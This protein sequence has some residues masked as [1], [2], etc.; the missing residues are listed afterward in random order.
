MPFALGGLDPF[1][2]NFAEEIEGFVELKLQQINLIYLVKMTS[3]E[4]YKLPTGVDLSEYQ[5]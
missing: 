3:T 2:T 4:N 5:C 1:V